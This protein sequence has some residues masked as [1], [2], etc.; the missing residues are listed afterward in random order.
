MNRNIE[1]I[2]GLSEGSEKF[3]TLDFLLERKYLTME[4]IE[5]YYA[6]NGF[7]NGAFW[8]KY[9]KDINLE[10]WT[11]YAIKYKN[12]SILLGL[13]KLPHSNIEKIED[14]FLNQNVSEDLI[15]FAKVKGKNLEKIVEK[16]LKEYELGILDSFYYEAYLLELAKLPG[17]HVSIIE[18]FFLS[19]G[20]SN[21][22]VRFVKIKG[23]DTKKIEAKVIE[24]YNNYHKQ[25]IKWTKSIKNK[26]GL[27]RI[28][29]SNFYL[30]RDLFIELA[31]IPGASVKEL[32][33]LFIQN[34]HVIKAADKGKRVRKKYYGY[35]EPHGASFIEFGEKV[36][37]ANIDDLLDALLIISTK[38]DYIT[39]FAKKFPKCNLN[40]IVKYFF[41]ESQKNNEDRHDFCDAFLLLAKLSSERGNIECLNMCVNEILS[42][43]KDCVTSKLTNRYYNH[44]DGS[45]SRFPLG[46]HL[47]E[48]SQIR[49]VDPLALEELILKTR[50]WPNIIKF[51]RDVSGANIEKIENTLCGEET[52]IIIGFIVKTRNL[53]HDILI[54][55]LYKRV[56]EIPSMY[57]IIRKQLLFCKTLEEKNAL[58]SL[59]EKLKS[60]YFDATEFAKKVE[61]NELSQKE[62]DELFLD[63]LFLDKPQKLVRKPKNSQK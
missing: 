49:G 60:Q 17:N 51:A 37:H 23:K 16:I 25:Y 22:L 12:I 39:E 41:A 7:F 45:F 2:L 58:K 26:K 3:K 11:D 40:K 61:N 47:Y 57:Q 56:D 19:R 53:N 6:K 5:E 27:N 38:Y 14:F 42:I 46:L 35:E 48:L 62:L 50:D 52:C 15:E 59:I 21:N 43:I 20:I 1:Q 4:E 10:R 34:E 29:L 54:N 28:C 30:Y 33:S 24:G 18:D 32:E 36:P 63:K 9:Q 31:S 44:S 8:N 13:A 55:E